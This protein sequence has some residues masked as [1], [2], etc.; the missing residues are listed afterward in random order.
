MHII[1]MKIIIKITCVFITQLCPNLCWSKNTG[2]GWHSLLQGIFPTL[3]SSPG[4]PHCRQILYC[5]SQQ[6]VNMYICFINMGFPGGSMGKESTWYTSDTG[7]IG[8]IS[9]SRRFPGGHGNP[10][11]C[12]AWKIHSRDWQAA[13]HGTAKS[14]TKLKQLSMPEHVYM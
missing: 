10:L 8:L 4:L 5:L 7:D 2:V 13:V 12:S 11:Q 3:G 14:Q 1:F 6:A 9:G